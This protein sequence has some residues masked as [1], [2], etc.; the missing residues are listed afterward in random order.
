MS[1]P[2]LALLGELFCYLQDRLTGKNL[3]H[4]SGP[5]APDSPLLV[6]KEKISLR[7]SRVPLGV[8][9]PIAPDCLKVGKIT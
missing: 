2:R 4:L 1:F 6:D 7:S 9:T 8:E 5:L 3:I